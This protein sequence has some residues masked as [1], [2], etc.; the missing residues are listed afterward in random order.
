MS[1]E[2]TGVGFFRDSFLGAAAATLSLFDDF[3]F[4]FVLSVVLVLAIVE[5]KTGA[6][7]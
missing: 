6:E 7:D 3:C 4:V 1:L 2:C 5:E